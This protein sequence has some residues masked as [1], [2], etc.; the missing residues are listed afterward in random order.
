MRISDFDERALRTALGNFATGVTIVTTKAEGNRSL[1]L[2]VSSFNAVSL[3]P[4][5]ILFSIGKKALAYEA[6]R[7][8]K[9]FVVNILEEG[10]SELSSRFG[11]PSEDK[12]CG[13]DVQEVEC[14]FLFDEAVMAFECHAYRTY[15]GGD[16][17]ILLGQV[18]AFHDMGR[19]DAHPL[20]FYRGRY[21][22]IDRSGGSVPPPHAL[23][24]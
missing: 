8:A 11:R 18:V 9:R 20:V 13:L 19:K 10:Q 17:D 22:R 2:T 7:S 24:W 16:H 1:G 12:W 3:S 21:S 4:P 6:W 15:D 23:F 14:G 5:L